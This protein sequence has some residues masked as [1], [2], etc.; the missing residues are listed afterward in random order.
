[1]AS[2]KRPGQDW[3]APNAMKTIVATTC[4]ARW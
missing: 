2:P 1:M 3:S 4:H